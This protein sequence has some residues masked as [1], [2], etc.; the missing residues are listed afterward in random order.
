MSEAAN[1]DAIEFPLANDLREIA[2]VAARID[3]F[4]SVRGVA[5]EIA[6][7]VNL[8]IDELL[9]NTISYGYDDE[10]PHRIEVIVRREGETLVVVI[11]DDG[12]AFDPTQMPDPDVEAPLEEREDGGLGL[13]LV[14]QM[15]DS[16]DY[17]RRA[18][19]NVVTLTKNR[20]REE[21]AGGSI[22]AETTISEWSSE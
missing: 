21:S 4:C 13:L 2:R 10:D 20:T 12:A 3:E 18:G 22:G 7:A 19:C 5:S 15:M 16:V 6:Y 17:Q 14:N 8:A 1:G 9:T 11:V